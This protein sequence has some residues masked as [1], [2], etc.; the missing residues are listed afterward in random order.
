MTAA[1][2]IPTGVIVARERAT[3]PWQSYLWRPVRVVMNGLEG[4]EW[5]EVE[6]GRD[7]VH[8][9]AATLPLILDDR[10]KVG[11]RINLV[12]GVPSVYVVFKDNS[13]EK[14]AVPVSVTHLT[15]SPFEIQNVGGQASDMVER[16]PMPEPLVQFLCSFVD[17]KLQFNSGTGNGNAL[18]PPWPAAL[19]QLKFGS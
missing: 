11:Y 13:A 6:R 2:S 7:Y 15:V 10:E 1:I 9:Y 18:L 14:G 17:D 12:N 19:T 4:R 3:N 5:R 8:Y 16:V